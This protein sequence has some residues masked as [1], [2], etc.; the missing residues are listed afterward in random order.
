MDGEWSVDRYGQCKG[1]VQVDDGLRKPGYLLL[2]LTDWVKLLPL[3]IT[4][5]C[6]GSMTMTVRQTLFADVADLG[7]ACLE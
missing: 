4:F 5:V 6:I 1:Q 3:V 7:G 2:A